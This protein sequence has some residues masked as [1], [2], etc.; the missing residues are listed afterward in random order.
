M[1]RFS[2]YR[3]A[4]AAVGS[5][6]RIAGTYGDYLRKALGGAQAIRSAYNSFGGGGYTP[7]SLNAMAAKRAL[8]Y[9]RRGGVVR[10]R[11]R[12]YKMKAYRGRLTGP[13]MKYKDLDHLWSAGATVNFH[14]VL[15]GIASGDGESQRIG[16]KVT[17]GSLNCR[18]I[19]DSSAAT[20]SAAVRFLIVYDRQSNGS[21]VLHS[22]VLENTTWT[23]DQVAQRKL[24][25]RERFSILKD[26]TIVI[27]TYETTG[28]VRVY[29]FFLP[30]SLNVVYGGDGDTYSS[31]TTGGLWLIGMVSA[32]SSVTVRGSTRVRYFDI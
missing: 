32:A 8:S 6:L 29:N 15:N 3:A 24:E 11:G 1:D 28:D 17:M 19:L 16:R 9:R 30:M 12:A 26:E 27:S 7:S 23:N 25:N 20:G 31:I 21:D 4:A 2:R 14:T 22:D 13:E 18:F 10:S 5:G